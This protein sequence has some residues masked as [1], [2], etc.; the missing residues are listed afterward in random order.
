MIVLLQRVIFSSS[1][2][3]DGFCVVGCCNKQKQKMYC[4]NAFS[5]KC[6][7]NLKRR[8]KNEIYFNLWKKLFI[9]IFL[10]NHENNFFCFVTPVLSS[11][12]LLLLFFKFYLAFKFEE[13]N[14]ALDFLLLLLFVLLY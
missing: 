6:I 12:F 7:N 2:V 1:I 3:M 10:N 11:A 8:G 9:F 5:K 14:L 13:T 4:K